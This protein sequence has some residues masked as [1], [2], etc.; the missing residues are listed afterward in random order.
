MSTLIPIKTAITFPDDE[1]AAFCQRNQ[2]TRM[3]LFG[4]VLRQ[5]FNIESPSE[6]VT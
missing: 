6:E 2:I 4:S 3:G 5:D 1:I